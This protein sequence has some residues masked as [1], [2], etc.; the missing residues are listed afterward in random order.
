MYGRDPR[1]RVP[2]R[3]THRRRPSI[4]RAPG[5]RRRE[6]LPFC[7]R[8]L[9]VPLERVHSRVRKAQKG[10]EQYQRRSGRPQG[11][12]AGPADCRSRSARP[13]RAGRS[14]VR[15]RSGVLGQLSR[16]PGHGAV[17]RSPYHPPDAA[18]WAQDADFLNLFC[19]TGSATVYAAAGGAR[20]SVSVDMSNTYLD[21]AR[22]NLEFNELRSRG[23]SSSRPIASSG[24]CARR[25]R[26]RAS[27]SSSSIRRR[28]PIPSAWKACSTC[29]GTTWG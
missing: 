6:V 14:D 2:F 25:A 24:W 3:N 26:R 29:S 8:R 27:T 22:D 19:Y 1:E 4:R 23:T 15:G 13:L 11:R 5:E 20:S 17:P 21:W 12:P 18:G 28:S 7:P 10:T 16:L 9:G